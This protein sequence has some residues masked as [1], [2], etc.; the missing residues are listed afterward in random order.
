MLEITALNKA[1]NTHTHDM[2]ILVERDRLLS[3]QSIRYF[4]NILHAT[5]KYKYHIYTSVEYLGGSWRVGVTWDW[6]R[7]GT[8]SPRSQ[9]KSG[10]GRAIQ[11]HG[12]IWKKRLLDSQAGGERTS[13]LAWLGD[14]KEPSVWVIAKK[15]RFKGQI[16]L[17]NNPVIL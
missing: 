15:D 6:S 7:S 17:V 10:W 1:N 12:H 2:Y 3:S 4:H 8:T 11:R 13:A 5:F 14:G 9:L 16:M